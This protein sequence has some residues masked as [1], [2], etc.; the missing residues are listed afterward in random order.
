MT[1]I[2]YPRYFD[3]KEIMLEY[4]RVLS[5]AYTALRTIEE[6]EYKNEVILFAYDIS[7]YIDK[8]MERFRDM[9][10]VCTDR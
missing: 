8:K 1:R 5:H 2:R 3:D 6:G 10:F 7:G 9:V 4:N